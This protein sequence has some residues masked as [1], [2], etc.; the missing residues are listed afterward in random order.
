M[1]S[2]AIKKKIATFPDSPG[3]YQFKRGKG[4]N[5]KILYIGKATSLHD[6]VR[7][8]F[9]PDIVNTRNPLI[10][11]MLSEFDDIT[12]QKTNSVLEALILEAYLIKK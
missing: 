7:S 5:S 1:N 9:N 3:V 6:R 10:S 8:Y 12:Y 2:Q 11:K 4:N